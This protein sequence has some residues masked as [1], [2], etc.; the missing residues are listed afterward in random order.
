MMAADNALDQAEKRFFA[1]S[2]V[3]VCLAGLDG[4]FIRLGGPWTAL[5][6][7]TNEELLARRFLDFVH[8][9]DV[10]KTVAV[11][12]G[13]GKGLVVARFSNRYRTRAGG[14]V[15]LQWDA[16]AP[17]NGV[18][19]AVAQDVTDV[20]QRDAAL[21]RRTAVLEV[22]DDLHRGYVRR[23]VDGLQLQSTL[24]TLSLLTR[25]GSAFF[26][27]VALPPG[28]AARLTLLDL[29]S[30]EGLTLSEAELHDPTAPWAE[31]LHAAA[32]LARLAAAQSPSHQP[33]APELDP[34]SSSPPAPPS[35]LTPQSFLGLPIVAD[36]VMVGVLALFNAPGGFGDDDAAL[37]APVCSA[38]GPMHE[39]QRSRERE[40]L[41]GRE[42]HRW[43]SLA[44]ATI[45]ATSVI[46]IVTAP[47]GTISWMSSNGLRMLGG[48]SVDQFAS[49]QFA[50]LVDVEELAE[51]RWRYIS[52]FGYLPESDFL[53]VCLGAESAPTRHNW[54]Y[55]SLSG[56]RYPMEVVTSALKDDAGI[57]LGWTMVAQE[58]AASQAAEAE[59]LRLAQLEGQ[60]EELRRREFEAARISETYEYVGA[61]RSLR[62]SLD[63]IANFL[64]R[65]YLEH[66][67]SLLVPRGEGA[68]SS[69][70]AQVGQCVT[71]GVG[72]CWSLKTGQVFVS[73]PH[74]LRCAHI[75]DD[76]GAW[77]CVPLS[78]GV[79][80]VAVLS[81]RQPQTVLRHTESER[82]QQ[83]RST[84]G[85]VNQ[86]GQFSNVL[87]NLRLRRTLEEQATQDPL[88]GAVNRR[89][90]ER[91]LRMTV[92]RHQ[93]IGSRF[94]VLMVD[95]DHFK[96]INDQF[97]HDR[98]DRVLSGLG[99]ILRKRLRTSDVLARVG[100]EEFVIVLR[101]IE[102]RDAVT[103]AESLRAVIEGADLIGEGR[104]CTCSI[105]LVHVEHLTSTTDELMRAADRA[106]YVA[107]STGRNRVVVG[108]VGGAEANDVGSDG[109]PSSPSPSSP[110]S[111]SSSPPSSSSVDSNRSKGS[112]HVA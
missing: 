105:G 23:G 14:W 64:P 61:S 48:S 59:K 8:P 103:V 22:V 43:S 87:A 71:V 24:E 34:E 85:L 106:L 99:A 80:T 47:R 100:G 42:I 69:A 18:V 109:A 19:L 4:M 75:D 1:E 41:M 39:I 57:L 20:V 25:A 86:A 31:V 101:D 97:G 9:D 40:A 70:R 21:K 54:T 91:E 77:V 112:E 15:V 3:L 93:K 55:V 62:E 53:L 72:D 67:P 94:A 58:Q 38:L 73:E 17:K 74:S 2:P 68:T 107:K 28:G 32:P 6:G 51:A 7:W 26:A 36:G 16:H 92:S 96:K 5:L 78:D 46:V 84:N 111:P 56:V 89:Q 35:L 27:R 104:P 37:L 98:G 44:Q 65:I 60:L 50:G 110:P 95:V 30:S 52:Q 90:L 83:R 49:T 45:D 29:F 10:D 11:L 81:M 12:D 13:L 66:T 79:R 33:P 63:V 82:E 102:A 88:T 76:D 108:S